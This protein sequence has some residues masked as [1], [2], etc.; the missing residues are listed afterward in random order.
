MP[1][2]FFSVPFGLAGLGASWVALASDGRTPRTVGN[3]LP[4]VAALVWLVV[5]AGYLRYA[6][7]GWSAVRDDLL[8]PVDAPFGSLA[9]IVGAAR[10]SRGLSGRPAHAGGGRLAVR[11][12]EPGQQVGRR[13]LESRH[14]TVRPGDQ[15]RAL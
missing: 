10:P 4:A 6:V 9:V 1:L 7:S 2:K 5:L 8:D 11:G 3:T 13:G 15:H 14:I 12:H